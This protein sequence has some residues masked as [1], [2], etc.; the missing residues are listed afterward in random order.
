MAE[1]SVTRTKWVTTRGRSHRGNA[2]ARC[3]LRPGRRRPARRGPGLPE[4]GLDEPDREHLAG[5]DD[6]ADDEQER[7][8]D[9][10]RRRANGGRGQVER[11]QPAKLSATPKGCRSQEALREPL[12]A[13]SGLG[14]LAGAAPVGR[15]ADEQECRRGRVL[16]HCDHA[17]HHREPLRA[18]CTVF[19]PEHTGH[20][21]GVQVGCYAV[22]VGRDTLTRE[23]IVRGAIELLDAEGMDGLSMRVSATGSARGHRGLLA[24]RQQGQPHRPCQRPGVERDRAARPDRDRLADGRQQMATDLHAMLTRHPW[25]VQAFGSFLLYGPGKARHDDH[26]LALYE[27]AGFTGC[28]PT[29]RRPPSLPSCS[30]T[31]S[32]R[33]GGLAHQEAQPRWRRRRGAAARQHGEAREIATHVPT[34]SRPPRNS[35]A[36]DYAAAPEHSFEFGLHAILDGLEARLTAGRTSRPGRAQ[37]PG[38]DRNP[39]PRPLPGHSSGSQPASLPCTARGQ[40]QAA[41]RTRHLAVAL[42]RSVAGPVAVIVRAAGCRAAP[43]TASP[44]PALLGAVRR[45][46]TPAIPSTLFPACP[47]ARSEGGGR[48]LRRSLAP[49]PPRVAVPVVGR[50]GAAPGAPVARRPSAGL[51]GGR[52]RRGR[53]PGV[54]RGGPP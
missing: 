12:L 44:R 36:A 23:Q 46:G 10:G 8:E 34:S 15:Q 49:R 11:G 21:N 52:G 19:K 43:D 29:G 2:G 50:L 51:R 45:L 37:P 22:A 31:L 30:A 25:L 47:P 26:I 1:P 41:Q 24:R 14:A 53:R 40:E 7:W 13:S 28:G 35:R 42:K 38:H 20:L 32:A 33:L 27:A 4:R 6:S 16:Q 17:K 48:W 39:V 5:G 9:P 3:R 54:G 18:T